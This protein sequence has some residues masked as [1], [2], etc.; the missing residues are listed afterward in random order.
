MSSKFEVIAKLDAP[1]SS[2][3]VS[4]RDRDSWSLKTAKKHA[5][6][7]FK[8]HGRHCDVID[9][10]LPLHSAPSVFS[11]FGPIGWREGEKVLEHYLACALW[12]ETDENGEPLDDNYNSDDVSAKAM[13]ASLEFIREFVC[14]VGAR[15]IRKY[16]EVQTLAQLGHDLWL[17]RNGHGAGFWDRGLGELGER[18]TAVCRYR[19]AYI[20]VGDDGLL[21]VG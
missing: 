1:H 9:A 15:D 11:T 6:A 4:V 20:Y 7:Y 5:R 17:T 10:D 14:E 19:D 13:A 21:Y 2:G 16:L 3:A 12:A 18:L 8:K